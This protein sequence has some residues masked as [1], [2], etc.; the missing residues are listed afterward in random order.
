[1]DAL[2]KFI[3]NYTKQY[4]CI[5]FGGYTFA[6]VNPE[7]VTKH[8]FNID[9]IDSVIDPAI[10]QL[11]N[12]TKLSSFGHVIISRNMTPYSREFLR[13]ITRLNRVKLLYIDDILVKPDLCRVSKNILVVD[14]PHISG[15]TLADI[16]KTIRSVKDD[17]NIVVFTLLGKREL[18]F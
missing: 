1:M 14:D 5:L 3:P 11:N 13:R 8:F 2:E 17:D 6:N 12:H 18:N 10:R 15:S 7:N 9:D 16:I 4:N